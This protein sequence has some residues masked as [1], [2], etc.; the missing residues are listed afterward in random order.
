MEIEVYQFLSRMDIDN[1]SLGKI[2]ESPKR[3]PDIKFILDFEIID[4]PFEISFTQIIPKRPSVG[5]HEYIDPDIDIY[6]EKR[7]PKCIKGRG[8][9]VAKNDEF[10]NIETLKCILTHM[11]VICWYLKRHN[12]KLATYTDQH[13]NV[14]AYRR[15]YFSKQIFDICGKRRPSSSEN[16]RLTEVGEYIGPGVSA[17][18]NH[19]SLEHVNEFV[20]SQIIPIPNPT[21]VTSDLPRIRKQWKQIKKHYNTYN[22]LTDARRH[23]LEGELKACIRSAASA[24]DAI[25][26]Y[27]CS[28]WGVRF[29]SSRL[30]FDQKIEDVLMSAAKPSYQSVSSINSEK[31][32]YLYRARNSMHEGDCY[33]KDNYG[34]VIQIQTKIQVEEF[35]DAAEQFTLWIDSIA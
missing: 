23:L 31:L 33:Y 7:W 2:N 5:A 22:E 21:N 17:I 3:R 25:L 19:N 16:Y 1:F 10:K 30:S 4:K 6:M 11:R 20:W 9:V 27:Y 34:K 15:E 13:A 18:I 29:P 28:L 24:V 14:K 32:L 35:I 8:K 26:R 12:K